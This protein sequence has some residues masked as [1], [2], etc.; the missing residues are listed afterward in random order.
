[1]LY[2]FSSKSLTNKRQTVIK[3]K[4]YTSNSVAE[5]VLSGS[6][7]DYITSVGNVDTQADLIRA[8]AGNDTI[9]YVTDSGNDGL[10]IHGDEGD[11]YI[12][13]SSGKIY[14]GAGSDT[15]NVQNTTHVVTIYGGTE[16]GIGEISEDE[17]NIDADSTNTKT[18]SST[19]TSFTG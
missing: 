7:N 17:D 4:I 12:H 8:G 15:I 5:T 3:D 9:Y 6:G 18:H 2:L 14:G 16:D 13:T 19:L 10:I 11:D 1:M